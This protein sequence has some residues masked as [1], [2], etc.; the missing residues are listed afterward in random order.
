MVEEEHLDGSA[1]ETHTVRAA[2]ESLAEQNRVEMY[3]PE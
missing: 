1:V 2:L 3:E